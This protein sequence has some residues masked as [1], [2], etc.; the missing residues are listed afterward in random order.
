VA[1][2]IKDAVGQPLANVKPFIIKELPGV[3][4]GIVGLTTTDMKNVS[5]NDEVRTMDFADPVQTLNA[6]IPEMKKQG[7]EVII[8][9]SHMGLEQD[10]LLAKNMNGIDLIVGG[11]SHNTLAEPI[12]VGD[13]LIAQT[14]YG[15][16]NLGKVSLTWDPD[17]KSI[18]AGEGK[19]IP[20]QGDGVNSDMEINGI[21]RKYQ[22]K[23]DS[24]MEVKLGESSDDMIQP[25]EGRESNL[26]NLVTDIMRDV[27]G[28]D[29]AFLNSGCL[30]TNISKGEVKYKDVYSVIPFDS[31]IVTLK[32]QGKDILDVVERSIEHKENDKVLQISGLQVVY[33]STMLPGLRLLEVRTSDGKPFDKDKEYTV[34]TIDFLAKGGDAYTAFTKGQ[35]SGSE[36]EVLHDAVAK[37]VRDVGVLT[38]AETGRLRD[39][40]GS[41]MER[42]TE[43]A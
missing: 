25:T 14:G 8:V 13:T 37:K 32:M 43:V 1:A 38:S 29:I 33:D 19:L 39:I 12:K 40:D 10:K 6:T 20:V 34:A 22:S 18:T 28:T 30:R 24:I 27:A 42:Q 9:L 35:D 7:A 15:G 4:V 26:G 31:K 16:K 17:K 11:H 5:G 2:N 41:G 3:K 23:L 21:I 36:G